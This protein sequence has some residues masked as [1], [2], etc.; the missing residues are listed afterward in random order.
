MQAEGKGLEER[1]AQFA[2]RVVNV[3]E[4]I[5]SERLK[6]GHL[7]DQKSNH[8]L[9]NATGMIPQNMLRQ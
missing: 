2:A 9:S 6:S 8:S 7:K 1:T 5:P 4:A 3:C